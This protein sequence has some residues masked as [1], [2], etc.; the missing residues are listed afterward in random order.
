MT[1]G[2]LLE[3]CRLFYRT[4]D[5]Q[6]R[7]TLQTRLGLR[8][9]RLC[10]ALPRHAHEGGVSLGARLRP[11]DNPRRAVHRS[12]CPSYATSSCAPCSKRPTI[13]RARY[14]S[15]RRHRGGRAPRRLGRLI[16]R[17]APVRGPSRRCSR[18]FGSSRHLLGWAPGAGSKRPS[19]DP[20]RDPPDGPSGSSTPTASPDAAAR[21]A[22]HSSRLGPDVRDCR[23]RT[24]SLTL[25]AE[26]A[27]AALEKSCCSC[28]AYI[29]QTEYC[30]H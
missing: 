8:P 2:Q 6:L 4:W 28:T 11:P 27:L 26:S 12:G 23:C 30:R 24:S 3:Y 16:D 25:A 5:N 13:G 10:D 1:P 18:G 9:A 17:P 20:C 7:K 15:P 19:L 29:I 14:S 21:I 22:P